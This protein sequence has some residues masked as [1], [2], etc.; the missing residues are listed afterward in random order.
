MSR[1]RL[2]RPL[3]WSGDEVHSAGFQNGRLRVRD[4][5]DHLC[6]IGRQL[7]AEPHAVG[8]KLVQPEQPSVRQRPK[9]RV[10]GRQAV[11]QPLLVPVVELERY[12]TEKPLQPPYELGVAERSLGR[13]RWRP[14]AGRR[15][16]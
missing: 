5:A 3:A 7:M 1:R 13:W 16:G 15:A 12:L 4:V 10:E 11:G 2:R 8:Q 9:Q 14:V 6:C